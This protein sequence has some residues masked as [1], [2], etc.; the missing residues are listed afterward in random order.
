MKNRL[1]IFSSTIILILGLCY[2]WYNYHKSIFLA[3]EA[4]VTNE[5]FPSYNKADDFFIDYDYIEANKDTIKIQLLKFNNQLYINKYYKGYKESFSENAIISKN[6]VVK[7]WNG[8]FMN[9]WTVYYYKL[10][11]L[12]DKFYNTVLLDDN[13][14]FNDYS[15]NLYEVVQR[16]IKT[17][18]INRHLSDNNNTTNNFFISKN[19]TLLKEY[20]YGYETIKVIDYFRYNEYVIPKNI[21]Y[22]N[23]YSGNKEIII[24]NEFST[25]DTLPTDNFND[26]IRLENSD[27]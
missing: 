19:D 6:K 24:L 14:E 9:Q 5:F 8:T 21:I 17:N 12:Q 22:E 7:D 2:I 10:F 3:M 25:K 26:I 23:L 20:N 15:K 4:K 11:Y 13:I 27:Q 16:E 18:G 1:L